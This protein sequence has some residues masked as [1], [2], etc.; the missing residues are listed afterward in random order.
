MESAISARGQI[1]IPKEVCRHLGLKPGD[2]VK[3]FVHADGAV[4]LLPKLPAA[5]LRGM[6]LSRRK[7]LVSMDEMSRAVAEG[8]AGVP[9]NSRRKK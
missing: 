1:T 2:C 7:K 9:G 4:V 5:A 3:F 6:S 8:A